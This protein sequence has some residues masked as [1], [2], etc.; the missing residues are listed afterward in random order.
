MV[1]QAFLPPLPVVSLGLE[2]AN[3]T[4]GELLAGFWRFFSDFLAAFGKS[5]KPWQVFQNSLFLRQLMS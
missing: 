2:T 4:V 3:F 1:S 5:D